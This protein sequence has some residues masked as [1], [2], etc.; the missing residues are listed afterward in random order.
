MKN[1][2]TLFR[3]SETQKHIE[4]NPAVWNRLERQL[5]RHPLRLKNLKMYLSIAAGLAILFSAI[6]VLQLSNRQS[7][8]LEDLEMSHHPTLNAAAISQ[9]NQYPEIYKRFAWDLNG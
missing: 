7:Y 2:D 4:L 1:I 5:D 8:H 6:M 3:E 9:M